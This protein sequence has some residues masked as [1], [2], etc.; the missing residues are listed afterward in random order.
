MSPKEARR[1]DL[2]MQYCIAATAQAFKDSKL[3]IDE[4]NA[5]DI[6]AIIGSG[7][8]GLNSCHDQFKI[9]FDRGPDRVSPFYITQFITDIAA[10]VVSMA[11]NA[12][13]YWP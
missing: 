12:S 9:L 13:R 8:G 10:G 3:E 4:S 7:I 5:D 2:F 6:G 11:V 1:M